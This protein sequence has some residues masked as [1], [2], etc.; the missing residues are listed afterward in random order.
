LDEF[1]FT[2]A[3]GADIFVRR[4]TADGTPRCAVVVV[5]GASEHSARYVRVAEVLAGRRYVV[6]ALDLPGHGRTAES[7]GAGRMGPRGMDGLLDDVHEVVRLARAD[8]GERPVVLFGHSMGSLVAQAFVERHE[9]DVDVY[10]LSGTVGTPDDVE[11][12]AAGLRQAVTA[13]M[14]DEPLDM[15]GQFNAAFEPARTT[16]DWLSRD[17]DEVDRYIADPWCGDDRPLTY[18][19]VAALLEAVD[20]MGAP[21][22]A[23]V[24]DGM[25][26][27]LLTGEA[28][29][30]SNGG[31]Q[32]RELEQRLRDTGLD[33][34]A[35][36]YPGAR[37]EVL[38][39]TNRDEVH[40]D[41]LDWLE[42]GTDPLT[43]SRPAGAPAPRGAD[44]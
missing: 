44:G 14:G 12:L 39:E 28:D 24:P 42:R 19:F 29:P 3:D 13:G 30:A 18:G 32:V 5:H 41:L 17:A 26:V 34:T 23:R 31:Q 22:V 10:A 15:F 6:Y 1:T 9:D 21:A 7:T 2:D 27:L 40:A 4:W 43:G 36:Y 11:G 35:R 33:V 8:V 25:P 20:V 38:N 37:H 16:Y